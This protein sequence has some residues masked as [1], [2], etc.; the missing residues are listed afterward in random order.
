MKLLK[1]LF[2]QILVLILNTQ[3]YSLPRFSVR[4][5]D[6]CVDCHYN[7]TGG[8]IR[9]DNGF[10]YGQNMLSLISPRTKDF[11]MSP[12]LNDNISIG[13]D[14]RGQFLYSQEK[15]R[16]DF[17]R[18]SGS[19]YGRVGLSKKIN[20]LARYDFVNDIWE[21]YGVAQILP[22]NS[23]IKAGSFQPNFG[24][25]LDDHTAYT[26]GGDFFLLFQE[27][28][29]TGLIYDPFYIE[30]GAEL[31]IYLSDFIFLTS[32]IGTN[33]NNPTLTKDPTYTARLELTPS[34]GKIGFLL[35]GSYAAAKVPQKTEMYGG[36]A[37]I[38]Y[39]RFSLLAEFDQASN[40]LEADIKSNMLMIEAVYIILIGLEAYARY[41]WL[42]KDV[43]KG[44]ETIAHLILGFEF[45]PYS[46]IEIRPQ[47]RFIIEDP[48][49]NN[50]AA[51]IQ[52]HFWY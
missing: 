14:F 36:F 23:Y 46:F 27:G 28:A 32:S 43:N 18:M 16:T 40:L 47:Y 21:A 51:V 34:I 22:N 39:D 4:L 37:G 3:I 7:P 33:L 17:Q 31:G 25:R 19:V 38:G 9:N 8:I 30:A 20:I 24:I 26:R 48:N 10:F 35:G 11:S 44:T 13:L 5:G 6:K 1:I 15:K 52:F 50:D 49:L 41:D 12:K 29:R 42:D 2:V 45:I